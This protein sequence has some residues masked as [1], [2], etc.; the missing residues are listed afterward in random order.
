MMRYRCGT[1]PRNAEA[2]PVAPD[3]GVGGIRSAQEA[4]GNGPVRGST[5][6]A[7]TRFAPPRYVV[8]TVDIRQGLLGALL[9]GQPVMSLD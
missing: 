1:R 8:E 9:A 7:R 5:L 4:A 2:D 6:P 3:H